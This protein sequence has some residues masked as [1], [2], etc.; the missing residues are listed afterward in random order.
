MANPAE[1]LLN[2]QKIKDSMGQ[3][4]NPITN[5]TNYMSVY[6]GAKCLT[7]S[8][9]T[10]YSTYIPVEQ[11]TFEYGSKPADYSTN[12]C[13][14]AS[15]AQLQMVLVQIKNPDPSAWKLLKELNNGTTFGKDEIKFLKLV[16]AGAQKFELQKIFL[17][18]T[19]VKSIEFV[20]ET[21][22]LENG[23]YGTPNNINILF[24]CKEMIIEIGSQ[25][26]I[27]SYTGTVNLEKG[28]T[29]SLI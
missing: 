12:T 27:G 29:I 8:G 23:G 13:Q 10:G 2:V 15:A 28:T 4:S 17:T 5:S 24:S 6:K 22:M 21:V 26:G 3:N 9:I 25:E 1:Q 20:S 7:K 18:N 11:M 19:I 14:N 16:N